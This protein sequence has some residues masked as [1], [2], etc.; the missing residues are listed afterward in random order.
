M[1]YCPDPLSGYC[2]EPTAEESERIKQFSLELVDL[3]KHSDLCRM[4]FARLVPSYHHHFGRQLRVSDYGHS[5]LQDLLE[6]L[7]HIV[8]VGMISYL[9]KNH[10]ICSF[11]VCLSQDWYHHTSGILADIGGSWTMESA[12]VVARNILYCCW[13]NNIFNLV[14][15]TSLL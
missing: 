6:S 15:Y 11:V 5:K 14:S 4:P 2:V 10:S 3:L 1:Q 9:Y 12:I 8:E 7:T 13:D